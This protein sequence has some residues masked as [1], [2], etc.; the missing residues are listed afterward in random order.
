VDGN[1][2]VVTNYRDIISRGYIRIPRGAWY[3]VDSIEADDERTCPKM[4]KLKFNV[5]LDDVEKDERFRGQSD[6]VAAM[7]EHEQGQIIRPPGTG[8][9]QIALAF[10]AQCKTRTLVLVHTKDILEQWREYAEKAIPGIDIGIIGAGRN[11]VGHL[12]LATIQTVKQYTPP[13]QDNRKFWR[14]FGAVIA[15]ESHHGAA[16]SWE[17]V[18][19][20][21][22]ARYR[23]G[24]TASPTRADG[25]HPSLKF[26]LGPVIHRQKFS[27]PIDLTVVPVKTDFR[28]RWGGLWDWKRLLNFLVT[29]DERNQQI[30]EVADAEISG[31]NSVL[32]LSRRIEHLERIADCMREPNAILTGAKKDAERR[33][34]L[35]GLREG[36]IACVL[37]TQLADEALDVPRLNR[38]ILTFPGKHEG[39]LVQ[40]IGRAIREYPDKEDAIIYDFVDHR[41]GV[42]KRQWNLRRKAY[43]ANDVKIRPSRRLLWR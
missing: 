5:K 11:R 14:Q 40:Q 34:I 4:P 20:S 2:E 10:I 8:K 28:F 41:V 15:D 35:D 43:K 32:V 26:L 25:L 1:S 36:S 37:S 23:F 31:G 3:L 9:T 16:K 13:G 42:L 33:R 7:F 24:F 39:R 38:V 6:A 17:A 18:L 30:A 12:T 29:D 19:N 21:C 22:T 27:S